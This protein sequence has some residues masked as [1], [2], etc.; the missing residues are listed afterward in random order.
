MTNNNRNAALAFLAAAFL[1]VPAVAQENAVATA[2]DFDRPPQEGQAG[3][4]ANVDTGYVAGSAPKFQG[5]RLGD[6]DAFNYKLQAGTRVPLNKDWFLNL[7]LISD[8]FSLE[9]VSGAPIPADIHTLRFSAGLGYRLADKWTISALVSP[10]L[11]RL[12]DVRG[13]DLGLSGGVLARFNASPSL[14]LS[15]GM[16]GAAD[17]DIPVMPILGAR[18][19]INDR[20]TLSVG[21]PKTRL[22]YRMDAKWSLYTGL[23]FDGAIFRTSDDLGT[24]TG[25][26]QYNNAMGAY[27]DIRLGAGTGYEFMRGLRAE[28]EAGYSVYREINYFRIEQ[29]VK[30]RP[31]PYVRLALNA[32]F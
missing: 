30:F 31:A 10:S 13:A 16:F 2:G 4:Q 6:S 1:S 3:W 27:R 20:Y 9:Q 12:D 7:D 32:R 17:S 11:F 19:Q 23:D 26:P 29:T 28:I 21:M 8:N 18:W 22:S 24:K 5:T 14:T 25:F 15:F